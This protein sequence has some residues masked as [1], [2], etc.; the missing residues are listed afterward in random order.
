[1]QTA[2]GG[3]CCPIPDKKLFEPT[4]NVGSLKAQISRHDRHFFAKTGNATPCGFNIGRVKS[5]N[6][7][8]CQPVA[9]K[10]V[11]ASQVWNAA[12]RSGHSASIAAYQAVS[13]LRPL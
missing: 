9:S 1:M 6:R 8:R 10:L 2:S 12:R 5:D 11:G 13:R 7:V 3:E 4:Q